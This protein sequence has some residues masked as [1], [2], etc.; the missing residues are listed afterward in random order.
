MSEMPHEHDDEG[1]CLPP[2]GYQVQEH[3]LF[4]GGLPTWKWSPWDVA[5]VAATTTAGLFLTIG[6]GLN[7]LARE[8]N[9]MA[10]WTRRNYD[11][12]AEWAAEQAAKA[13][14][15]ETY[16]RLVGMD[17]HWLEQEQGDQQ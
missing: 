16:E 13:E 17:T 15:A 4:P 8:C 7:L 1:N 11:L 14:L 10:N 2:E 12:E 3:P 9:A 6:Q 5:G